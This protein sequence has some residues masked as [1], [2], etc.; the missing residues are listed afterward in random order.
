MNSNLVSRYGS[1]LN[2]SIDATHTTADTFDENFLLPIKLSE[3]TLKGGIF[4][5]E[6]IATTPSS[7]KIWKYNSLVNTRSPSSPLILCI[8]ATEARM[9]ALGYPVNITMTNHPLPRTYA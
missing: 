7:N 3:I 6:N 2:I 5:Y 4:F 9:R 1:Q 8:L